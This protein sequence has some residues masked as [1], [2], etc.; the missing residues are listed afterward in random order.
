MFGILARA[1][2]EVGYGI[3]VVVGAL[4]REIVGVARVADPDAR[5]GVVV[6]REQV[7]H[8]PAHVVVPTAVFEQQFDSAFAADLQ[9]GHVGRGVEEVFGHV[10]S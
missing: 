9:D 8:V 5:P 2:V 10:G 7:A 1:D 4:P 6:A 3:A